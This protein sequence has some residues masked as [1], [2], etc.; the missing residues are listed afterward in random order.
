[1]TPHLYCGGEGPS[2]HGSLGFMSAPH[3][4]LLWNSLAVRFVVSLSESRSS[5]LEREGTEPPKSL[6]QKDTDGEGAKP[7]T[8]DQRSWQEIANMVEFPELSI[9]WSHG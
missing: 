1:M 7:E 3:A 4:N 8:R 2:G 9:L 6:W 5:D